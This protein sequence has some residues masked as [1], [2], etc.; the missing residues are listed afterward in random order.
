MSTIELRNVSKVHDIDAD[1]VEAVS[2]IDLSI[3][4]GELFVLIGPSGCGKSTLLR[5]IAGIETP[6]S[7]EVLLDGVVV[8]GIGARGRDVAMVFQ[9]SALYP[10]M[11]VAENIGFSLVLAKQDRR[12]IERRVREMAELLGIGELLERRPASCRAA[13]VNGWPSD[14]C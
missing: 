10:N 7:G 3:A 9:A 5:L 12:V 6:S 4:D 8:N 2:D 1:A 11:S 14:G 13:S